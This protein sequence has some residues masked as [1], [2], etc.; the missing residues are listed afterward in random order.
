MTLGFAQNCTALMPG[1]SRIGRSLSAGWDRGCN[2]RDLCH[3]VE[4]RRNR[5]LGQ[6][7][8]D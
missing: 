4:P 6:S 8:S 2:D 1:K 7:S 5:P 3:R